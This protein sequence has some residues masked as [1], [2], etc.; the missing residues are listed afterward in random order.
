MAD[1]DQLSLIRYFLLSF[2]VSVKKSYIGRFLWT[3]PFLLSFKSFAHT[4]WIT[5]ETEC[6]LK[7]ESR[8]N[9]SFIFLC[10]FP[11]S[12]FPSLSSYFSRNTALVFYVTITR[13]NLILGYRIV[14]C[15]VYVFVVI[16]ISSN[17]WFKFHDYERTLSAVSFSDRKTRLAG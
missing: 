7:P 9:K 2:W 1:G 12:L 10:L 8:N 16:F 11:S 6:H 3:Y 14:K 15:N 5:K 13:L 4:S 17:S